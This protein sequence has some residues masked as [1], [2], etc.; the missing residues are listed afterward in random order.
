MMR[1]ALLAAS[2]LMLFNG[3]SAL[4]IGLRRRGASLAAPSAAP[5]AQPAASPPSTAA[6]RD[7]HR[8]YSLLRRD[9]SNTTL[10]IEA[11]TAVGSYFEARLAEQQAQE[12]TMLGGIR[13]CFLGACRAALEAGEAHDDD[14]RGLASDGVRPLDKSTTLEL[15]KRRLG[16]LPD[17]RPRP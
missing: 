16:E 7:G 3:G 5:A 2:I 14:E 1:L 15:E 12:K 10:S 17:Y 9:I 8:A 6:E 11:L 4:F 13:S